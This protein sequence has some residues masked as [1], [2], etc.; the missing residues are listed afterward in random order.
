MLSFQNFYSKSKQIMG[1]IGYP[2][3]SNRFLASQL[4]L[5]ENASRNYLPS[6]FYQLHNGAL[7]LSIVFSTLESDIIKVVIS[8]FFK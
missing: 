6:C 1:S 2:Y 3:V 8:H 4:S 5:H 7:L